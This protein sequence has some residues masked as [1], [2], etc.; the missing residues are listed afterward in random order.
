[1]INRY[2]MQWIEEWCVENGW[3]DLF[4][5]R[6]DN[7]WAFPPGGVMPEP[8]PVHVLQVIKEENGLTNTEMFLAFAAVSTTILAIITT[9]WL[10]C[11]MPLVLSFGFNAFTVAQFEPEG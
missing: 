1:M 5:E 4:M 11:P 2:S 8:I 7:F 10:R 6:R 9:F 3:T